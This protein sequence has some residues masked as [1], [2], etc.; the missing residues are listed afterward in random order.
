MA[1]SIYPCLWF[2]GKAKEAADYYCA[3][4]PNSSITS[5]T[6]MVVKF[7]IAG[8]K[9]MA[10]NGGSMFKI[11]P[12]ISLFVHCKTKEEINILW[13]KLIDG[14]SA[15]M[16]LDQ[17]PWAEKYGWLI[18]KFGMTW[19]LMINAQPEVAFSIN[20]SLLFVNEQYG[21]AQ[22]A[23]EHYTRILQPSTIFHLEINQSPD[24]A[25]N[26]KLDFG[27]FMLANAAFSAMDGSG[28]HD[29]QF[30][31]GVSLVVECENQAILDQ[32]WNELTSEG[33][34]VQCGWLKDKFG[35]SWQIIPSILEQI[36]SD[37]AKAQRAMAEIMKMKKLD[38]FVLLNA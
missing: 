26:G 11:N 33:A 7:E 13:D 36:M 16:P 10:L 1:N 14:G 34:E 6:P 25:Q 19:Q 17:Y 31:E 38:I 23:I 30:N 3:I 27:H 5:N 24:E 37:P 35:V 8:Q 22:A 9:I 32:Y 15:M 12:S 21:N 4:F 2:D 20:P 29:F 28:K 18:D